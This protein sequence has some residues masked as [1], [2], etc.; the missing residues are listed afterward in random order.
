M[1]QRSIDLLLRWSAPGCATSDQG[2]YD[3]SAIVG[4]LR[5]GV[6]GKKGFPQSFLITLRNH[7][8]ARTAVLRIRLHAFFSYSITL[9]QLQMETENL[10]L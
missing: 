5:S 3:A 9:P 1:G 4:M 7:G 2:N 8:E 10:V 6:V